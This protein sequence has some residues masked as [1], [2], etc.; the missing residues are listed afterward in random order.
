[1]VAIA[2]TIYGRRLVRPALFSRCEHK[3]TNR[4]P[5]LI[6]ATVRVS[7]P[8]PGTPSSWRAEKAALPARQLACPEPDSTVMLKPPGE[9]A[10]AA[11]IPKADTRVAV[12]K[13]NLLLTG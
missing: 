10:E 7:R 2:V 3:K 8:R 5:G 12:T 11:P 9:V 13:I 4:N 1:M 6:L